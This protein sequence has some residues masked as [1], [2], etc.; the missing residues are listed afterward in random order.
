MAVYPSLNVSLG[1]IYVFL[2]L[3]HLHSRRHVLPFPFLSLSRE[4]TLFFLCCCNPSLSPDSPLSLS[5]SLF[6][7]IVLNL[8]IALHLP[9]SPSFSHAACFFHLVAFIFYPFIF[10]SRR[11]SSLCFLLVLLHIDVLSGNSSI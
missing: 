9:Q 10:L 1:M 3:A 8:S 6:L 5:L 4:Q 7:L 11:P 2:A